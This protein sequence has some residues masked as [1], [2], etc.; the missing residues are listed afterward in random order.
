MNATR[1]TGAGSRFARR[2]PVVV[3]ALVLGWQPAIVQ[4][5]DAGAQLPCPVKWE[6]AGANPVLDRGAAGAWDELGVQTRSVLWDGG[7]FL[8]YYQ[9]ANASATGIGIAESADGLNWTRLA[10]NPVLA[11]GAPGEWDSGVITAPDVIKDGSSY[12]MWFSGFDGSSWRIGFATS[13]DGCIWTKSAENPVLQPGAPGC[14]DDGNLSFPAVLRDGV[15][16]LMYYVGQNGSFQSIGLATS[17]DGTAWTRYPGNPVLGNGGAGT[18]ESACAGAPCVLNAS[19]LFRMWYSG[20]DGHNWNIGYA[21][22]D[23]GRNWTKHPANPVLRR[24]GEG[25]ESLGTLLPYV[26]FNGTGYRM[27]YTGVDASF[28]LRTGSAEGWNRAPDAPVLVAPVGDGW[29]NLSRPSFSWIFSDQDSSDSQGAYEIQLDA[30]ESFDPPDLATGRTASAGSSCSLPLE[31]PD[32]VWH[33]RVRVWDDLGDSGNWSATGTVRVDTIPPLNPVNLTSPG[34]ATASWS[35]DPTVKV[36]WSLPV[37]GDAGSGYAGFSVFWDTGSVSRPDLRP[38]LAAAETCATSPPL[39]DSDANYFHIRAQDI[40]G[41]WAAETVHLGPF[42]IDTTVP[43]NPTGIQSNTHQLQTWSSQNVIEVSWTPATAAISGIGGY[44]AYWDQLPST[45]PSPVANLPGESTRLLSPPLPDGSAL[46]LHLRS[47]DRAGNWA[48]S[49]SHLGP[50]RIDATAPVITRL[51]LD[52]G[53]R[54]VN[55]ESVP[56]NLVASD[57]S[58]GTGVDMMRFSIGGEVW[59]EWI[60]YNENTTIQL[61]GGDGPKALFVQV[62]DKL[63]NTCAPVN[64]NLILDQGAPEETTLTLNGGA[65]STNSTEVRLVLSCKEPIPGS[66]LA[67]LSIS[68]DG[69]A[70]GPWKPYTTEMNL[71]LPAG[72]GRKAV[73]ARVRDDAGN[74]GAPGCATILLDT[75]PPAIV[76]MALGGGKTSSGSFTVP[77]LLSVVDPEPSSGMEAMSF[78]E[79]GASWGAWIPFSRSTS[80]TFSPGDGNR[81]LHC[82]VWD[83]AGNSPVPA[84]SS[85]FVDTTPPVITGVEVS[86]ASRERA[87]VIWRTDEPSEGLVQ[88]GADALYGGVLADQVRSTV[89][90]VVLSGLQGGTLYHL[91]VQSTDALGNGPAI[92]IDCQFRTPKGRDTRAPRLSGVTVDAVNDRQ[93]R[94]SWETDEPADSSVEYGPTRALG[95]LATS[96]SFL[97]EHSIL[98][99]GLD[100]AMTYHFRVKSTDASLNRP[101]TSGTMNFTTAASPDRIAP[102]VRDIRVLSVSDK[103]AV[104][105]WSTSELSAPVLELSMGVRCNRT[106]CPGGLSFDHSALITGLVPSTV[107]SVRAGGMDIA[108]NGPAYSSPLAFTTAP[109]KD[110]ILPQFGR[111]KALSVGADRAI[112]DIQL[113]EPAVLTIIYGTTKA[114]GY[115]LSVPS[116]QLD[117]MV[118][119]IGLRPDSTYHYLLQATDPAGNGPVS[120]ADFTLHTKTA[121][122]APAPGLN[123]G[124]LAAILLA[125]A[126]VAGGS[127]FVVKRLRKRA[128][129]PAPPPAEEPAPQAWQAPE[130]PAPLPAE[131]PMAWMAGFQSASPPGAPLEVPRA[132]PPEKF[133]LVERVSVADLEDEPRP[134]PGIAVEP[135][136]PAREK[137]AEELQGDMWAARESRILTALS[138]L[139]RGLPSSLWGMEL[140]ELA[141]RITRAERKENPQ[142]DLIVKV[143]NRWYFGDE[144]NLGLFMQEYKRR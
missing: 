132:T 74:I 3:L 13:S 76:Q 135:P 46:Y 113:D 81:T 87:V 141:A 39:P 35:N 66:G 139:P 102:S 68:T 15:T 95:S 105:W 27:W 1:S 91:R 144:T 71:T 18:W 31:C 57:P 40:A 140:E 59:G 51:V 125:I 43:Q 9:G 134:V 130:V 49:A 126:A 19:G 114:Y 22:S 129:A 96:G 104:V 82:R 70:W 108:G 85:I 4:L 24:R 37:N 21:D 69:V 97:R 72:D 12:K 98:L 101:G 127:I 36:G 52:Q 55:H 7:R 120:S 84:R 48:S 115:M 75:V 119:L 64:S 124:L 54:S 93:A 47:L 33:Y 138:S 78:S 123:Y 90:S 2:I 109:D 121:P 131:E 16:Y 110:T 41:N 61:A 142:G 89:H 103:T 88:Y 50:F 5:Q 14:W 80:Y 63:G 65:A 28:V 62:R 26:Q 67:N 118:A 34:H 77:V 137:T 116:Y 111:V 42:F 92:G 106:I 94:I 58:P 122:V 112:I 32:G 100:P 133:T 128:A 143:N 86:A 83:A 8:L 107:Y 30:D 44:S 20:S 53:E 23:D 56:L 6:R 79:D 38:E 29:T 60:A 73:H 117:H 11:P 25:W 99:E 17:S 10:G 136:L 45:L